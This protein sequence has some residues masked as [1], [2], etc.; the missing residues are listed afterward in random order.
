MFRLLL[1][2]LLFPVSLAGV[3][4]AFPEMQ[5]QNLHAPDLKGRAWLNTE[6]PLESWKKDLKGHVVLL[7]FWTYCCINC[8]HVLPDLRAL[9]EEFKDEAFLVIGVHS[10]KFEQE[11]EARNI[12]QAILRYDIRHPVVVDDEHRIWRGF[13]VRAWP[14][15]VLVD[16]EGYV[17]GG[18]SGE[19]HLELLRSVIRR[20][21]D[22]H[23]SKGTLADKPLR[24]ELLQPEPT[25]LRYPGKVLAHGENVFVAD[26][27]GHRLLEVD[28][29]DGRVLR[30]FG[31]G[32]AGHRDGEASQAQFRNPQGM[33]VYGEWLYV[34]DTD[35]HRIRRIHLQK[36]TVDTV[37]GKG[38][39]ARP[40]PKPGKPMET[41]LNSPWALEIVGDQLYVAMAGS[42]QLWLIDLKENQLQSA[43]G[44]GR[45]NIVDGPASVAQLAQP[46]GLAFLN[47]KLYFADSEVS[48]VRFLDLEK[49]EVGTVL[50][51]GLFD[52]GDRDGGPEVAQLQHPLGLAIWKQQLLVAD[53]YNGKVRSLDPKTRTSKTLFGGE[54]QDLQFW[55]PGGLDVSGD[56]LYVAD[57]NNHRILAIDLRSKAWRVLL[58]GMISAAP[59]DDSD[60]EKETESES[61]KEDKS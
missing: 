9:E 47:G 45:E 5:Q 35:N 49:K 33:A 55:E 29:A 42:H 53:T 30:V 32:E 43:A 28:G 31:S 50:G 23:R 56:T 8:I 24:P 52:F 36:G 3:A 17:L 44:S 41:D 19:G 18:L 7:D 14:S 25:L 58:G 20:V 48:A 38:K 16:P 12:R 15:F 51:T 27:S 37:A 57:T 6:K 13:G 2:L 34:A 4:R 22:E 21:L 40:L 26:S 11:G 60:Q 1:G 61:A 39:Q 54:D 46:S 10:N 59:P